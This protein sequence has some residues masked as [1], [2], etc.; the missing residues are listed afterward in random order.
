MMRQR[1]P[2]VTRCRICK[3]A[4]CFFSVLPCVPLAKSNCAIWGSNGHKYPNHDVTKN[5][6]IS[7]GAWL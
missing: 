3:T 1:S 6:H 7:C 5:N 2:V 4:G